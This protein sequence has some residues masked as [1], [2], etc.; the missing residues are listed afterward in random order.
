MENYIAIISLGVLCVTLAIA[1]I[2]KLNSGLVSIVA[3]LA[4]TMFAG[5]KLLG[6]APEKFIMSSFNNS[7]FLMLLGVMY[8]FSLAQEN[9]TLEVMSKKTFALCKGNAKLLPIV[10]FMVAAVISAIG[11]GLISSTALI[12]VLVVALAQEMDTK[13]IRLVPFGLLGAFGG[14]LT[15]V[16]PTGI[17]AVNIAG[18]NGI[19]GVEGSVPWKMFVTCAIF[20]AVLYFFVFK[21]HKAKNIPI[22]KG[23]TVSGADSFSPKQIVTLAG[24]LVAA[25]VSSVFKLNVGLVSFVVAVILTL[26]KVSDETVA[27]KKVPWGTLIMITGVGIL[28]SVVTQLG[29]IDLLSN[30]LSKLSTDKTV[31][32]IMALL[33]GMMSW[34]SSAS[35][36]VMPTLIPTI[37][38]VVSSLPGADPLALVNCISIGANMAALSPLSTCG[39]LMLAAYCASG[40][41]TPK[42]RNQMFVQLFI[43]SVSGVVLTAVLALVGFY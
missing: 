12:S 19:Y 43:L 4:L 5:Q 39:A 11:P 14:G 1:F 24:I 21:W 17:V 36:V 40:N 32:P 10:I 26:F 2:F 35:G 34:V 9:K 6:A 31:A 15:P 38:D 37:P 27:L 18:E 25:A 28:I 22:Q 29:G 3:S 16:A 42:E 8:L 7:L 13:A 23:E 20:A 41:P 30:A 33:S